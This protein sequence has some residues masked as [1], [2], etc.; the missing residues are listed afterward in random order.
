MPQTP[1]LISGTIYTSRGTCSNS[2]V[3]INSDI[4]TTTNNRGQYAL[5]LANLSTGY[6]EGESY[7]IESYDEFN[8]EY[9]GDTVTVVGN[10]QT[11]DLFLI[12]REEG[13]GSP[14]GY[15]MELRNAGNKVITLDNPLHVINTDRRTYLTRRVSGASYPKY[16][17]QAS[18]GTPTSAAKWKIS[19]TKSNGEVTWANGNSQS[20]KV[21]DNYASYSY[22]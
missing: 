10:G 7:S 16:I 22:S 20:D 18:P 3:I 19:L 17:G 4:K 12:S 21:F 6:T 14:T 11:K 15:N 9:I 5:D 8:N 13:Q 2:T 1:Y